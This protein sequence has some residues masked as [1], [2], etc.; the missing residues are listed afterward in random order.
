VSSPDKNAF[1]LKLR[2]QAACT[3]EVRWEKSMVASRSASRVRMFVDTLLA[4]T[5]DGFCALT[6]EARPDHFNNGVSANQPPPATIVAMSGD[7]PF[8]VDWPT[9]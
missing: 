9:N 5:G 4:T 1:Y 7:A 6:S 2:V 3:L 8:S